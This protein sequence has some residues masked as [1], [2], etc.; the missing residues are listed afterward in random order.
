[1]FSLCSG[2]FELRRDF[3]RVCSGLNSTFLKLRR[4]NFQ[5]L[6]CCVLAGKL[7]LY[8][9]GLGHSRDHARTDDTRKGFRQGPYWLGVRRLFISRVELGV[10]RMDEWCMLCPQGGCIFGAG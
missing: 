5:A 1:M 9:L 6:I 3:A 7:I 2:I 4:I 10:G 8:L